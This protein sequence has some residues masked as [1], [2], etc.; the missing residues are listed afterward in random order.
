M[1]RSPH[2]APAVFKSARSGIVINPEQSEAVLLRVWEFAKQQTDIVTY[3]WMV[4]PAGVTLVRCTFAACTT[5][6]CAERLLAV[7]AQMVH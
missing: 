4:P 7:L 5:I 6:V 2:C 1:R 3:G